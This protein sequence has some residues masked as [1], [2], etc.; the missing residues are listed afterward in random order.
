MSL[1]Q[2]LESLRKVNLSELDANN[3]GSWP[4]PVKVMSD[5]S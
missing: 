3:L 2:S 4:A 1:A 5:G